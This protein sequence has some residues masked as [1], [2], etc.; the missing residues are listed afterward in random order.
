MSD[1]DDR[2]I[3]A[4]ELS[5]DKATLT[6]R[7]LDG[8]RE[9]TADEVAKL[10]LFFANLRAD[11]SPPVPHESHLDLVPAVQ[12]RRYE[13]LQKIEDGSAQ[14]YMQTP[15]LF[16]SYLHLNKEQAERM[17]EILNPALVVKSDRLAH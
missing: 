17:A 12:C 13:V 7:L 6:V 15:G 4:Y 16:W 1:S 9:Y 11:M 14:I 5:D 8:V 2:T 10:A 3:F